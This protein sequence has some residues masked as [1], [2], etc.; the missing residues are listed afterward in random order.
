MGNW[1]DVALRIWR[2]ELSYDE[3]GDEMKAA[4]N[5][6]DD[7]DFRFLDSLPLSW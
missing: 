6:L 5:A 2:K 7:D 4:V 1:D 3:T